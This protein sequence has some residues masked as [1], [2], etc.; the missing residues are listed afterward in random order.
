MEAGSPETTVQVP[1]LGGWGGHKGAAAAGWGKRRGV[2]GLRSPSSIVARGAFTLFSQVLAIMGNFWLAIG[3][4]LTRGWVA[5]VR[6]SRI[7]SA[8]PALGRGGTP[9]SSGGAAPFRG[10]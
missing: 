8:R 9:R 6:M 10:L 3:V 5:V 2:W 1:R 4:G 7:G